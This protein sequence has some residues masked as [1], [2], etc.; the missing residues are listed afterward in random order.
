MTDSYEF[1]K[2][3]APQSISLETPY[4][5]KQWQSVND[6]NSGIYSSN[7][8]T[9]VQFDL[10]SIYNSSSMID[11]AT[12]F[13]AIPITYVA[14]Y[15][16]SATTGALV[17]PVVGDWARVGLKNGY[18]QLVHQVDLQVNGK[19]IE[20][21]QPFTNSYVSFK[22]QS[23]M[24]ADDLASY[25]QS[26]G[27]GKI[28]DNYESTKYNNAG[29][30]VTAGAFPAGAGP[31]GGN[32]LINNAPFSAASNFG[33]QSAWGAQFGTAYNNGLYSRLNKM[34]DTTSLSSNNL[35]GTSTNAGP[36]ILSATNLAQEFKSTYQV[37]NTNYMTW[38]DVAIVRLCDICDSMKHMPLTKRFDGQIRLYLNSGVA[39]VAMTAASSSMVFSQSSTSFTNTCPLMISSN[40]APATVTCM[41]AGLFIGKATT[42]SQFGIN[43]ASSGASNP[44]TSCR[45]Y[46]AQVK[47]KPEI[48]SRYITENRHKKVVF[49][50]M[51]FNQAQS[52]TSGSAFSQ[53]VQSGVKNVRGVLTI[54]FISSTVNGLLTT[55]GTQ[56]SG[57]SPF[58]QL[59]SP[60]DTAPWTTSPCSIINYQ[61][62]IGGINQKQNSM[63]FSYE[64]WL[65][66]VS[67][68]EKLGASD[69]GLS[70]GL[71]GATQWEMA[72]R[73]YYIDCTRGTNADQI[74][75]RAVNVSFINNSQVTIDVFTIVEYFD[76]FVIDVETGIITK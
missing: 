7:G 28:V 58:S 18:F 55:G 54:P 12:A 73:Q 35:F 44:L 47:L 40:A 59:L 74:T 11:M 43:L 62:A 57:I 51:L 56:I 4:E 63:Y 71:L 32:G 66:E 76:D 14:A 5:S 38:Y 21:L 10:A 75:P 68:Y 34:V 64:S 17:P 16:S 69:I 50:A 46:Y 2:S 39:G 31:L 30:A 65:E 1:A 48:M 13:I 70:C 23:Q 24:S 53:L 37:L 61:V 52:I 49:T 15:A 36:V 9:L 8:T 22:L 42:T 45:F 20:Q 72:S 29:S 3:V 26:M 25:G 6:I 19:T 67:L 41:A 27:M 60:F 33:D